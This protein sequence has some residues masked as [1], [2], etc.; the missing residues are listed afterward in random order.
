MILLADSAVAVAEVAVDAAPAGDMVAVVRAGE[1]GPLG[2]PEVRFDGIEPGGVGGRGHRVDVQALEQRQEARM[3]MDIVQVIHNDEQA[4]ARVA[5]PQPAK[6]LAQLDDS[7][8]PPE[9][10]AQ[11][12][13]MDVVEAEEL[14]GAFAAMIGSPHAL[15]LAPPPP[16]D[17]AQRLEL[18]GPPLV[19]ADHCRPRRTRPVEVPDAFFFRSNAGSSEVFQVR[20]RWARRPSRRRSRRTHSSVIGGG[21]RRCPQYSASLGTVHAENGK[22]RSAGL[23]RAMSIS[24]RIWGPVT[25]GTRPFG[26]GGR[27]KVVKPLSLN[28]CTHSYTMVTLQPTPSAA[29]ATEPP[30][31]T[32]AITRYRAWSRTANRRSFTFARNTRCSPRV[33]VRSRTELAMLSPLGNSVCGQ[34]HYSRQIKF[35][36]H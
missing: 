12:V 5:C 1:R 19:E 16:G 27:S 23:D 17:P 30:R 11:A 35:D 29:S 28:R 2:D 31:A 6:G 20:M 13:G 15:R 7:L 18:Q 24:S 33:S 4:L 21:S 22:P 25:M 9:Q 8:A 36:R 26:L 10:A 34:S 32:S 3:I 14:L